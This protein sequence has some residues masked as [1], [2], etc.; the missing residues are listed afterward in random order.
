MYKQIPLPITPDAEQTFASF[1]CSESNKGIL[2]ALQ[3]FSQVESREQ[4]LYLWGEEGC[5]L[6]HLLNA[7]LNLQTQLVA[8][9]LPLRD[10]IAYPAAAILEGLDQ[11]DFV[12]IDDLDLI[13][14]K[15]DWQEALFNLYNRLR[16]T[17]KKL[18]IG[19]HAAPNGLAINL[20]DLQSRLQWGLVLRLHNLNDIEKIS[21]LQLY[22]EQQGMELSAEVANYLMT[23][24]ER[25]NS[26]LF[27]LMRKLNQESLAAQRKLTIPFVKANL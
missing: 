18:L 27:S 16:D 11:C 26:A 24:A 17:G 25:S 13:Q 10:L 7:C 15:S 14:D 4:F 5:G 9:Y 3:Q 22:A 23:R 8:Q 19:A 21:A 1:Y 20:K 2:S 6:S 12:C